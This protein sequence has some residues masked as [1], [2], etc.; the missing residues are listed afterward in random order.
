MQSETPQYPAFFE[1]VAK[2]VHVVCFILFIGLMLSVLW[3]VI[4][5]GVFLKPATFTEELARFIFIWLALIGAAAAYIDRAHL[6]V[7]Y[8]VKKFSEAKQRVFR[9]FSLA[10]VVAFSFFV[11]VVGGIMLML[12]TLAS[13]QLS[14][15]LNL[16]M[17]WVYACVPFAGIVIC[18]FA[19]LNVMS[20]FKGSN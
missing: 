1:S 13:S 7:D 2:G 19:S 3:Q 6:M 16:P 4:S 5:R 8:F 11:M 17:G 20:E 9:I 12:Q 14:P 15:V 10:I 18:V